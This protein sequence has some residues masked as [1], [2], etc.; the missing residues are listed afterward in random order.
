MLLVIA[1]VL[2]VLGLV[3]RLPKAFEIGSLKIEFE[4]SQ[5]AELLTLLRDELDEESYREA[6]R[7]L[8][9][10]SG[11]EIQ[12]RASAQADETSVSFDSPPP[13][14]VPANGPHEWVTHLAG[15]GGTV[16]ENVE[17]ETPGTR[18]RRPIVDFV[19]ERDERK[20]AVE[21]LSSWSNTSLKLTRSRLIRVLEQPGFSD[22][23]VVVPREGLEAAS[24]FFRRDSNIHV[25]D[26]A[27]AISSLS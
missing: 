6:E 13:A 10:A 11:A 9:A 17:I 22:A 5:V 8:R 26:S 14:G 18:G 25:V 23:T 3:G 20:T 7:L 27:G 21:W 12:E 16:S 24:D 19:I 15:P 2:L 1:G 4:V